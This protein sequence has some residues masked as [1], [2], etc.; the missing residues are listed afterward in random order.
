MPSDVEVFAMREEERRVKQEAKE[1][2]KN[3]SI[4]DKNVVKRKNFKALLSEDADD[5]QFYEQLRKRDSDKIL[6]NRQ[7]RADR[8]FVK[9][10]LHDFIA[11]KR[12]M[13]LVQYALGVKKEEM[14]KL[15]EIAQAEEQKLLDDE[16]ALEEDAG[17][18][19]ME[20]KAKLEKIQ[21]IKK[22]NV[23]IMSIRSDMSKNED[24][25]KD[26][27]RYR[28]FLDKLTPRE[29]FDEHTVKKK[30]AKTKPLSRKSIFPGGPGAATAA[31]LAAGDED[32]SGANS[33]E[34]EGEAWNEDDEPL[35]Y[36]HTPQQLLDI[37]AEL[38]EN[39]LAL[40][41]NCQETEET[42]EELKQKI[43]DT[44]ARMWVGSF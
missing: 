18:A 8:H 5:L 37:F 14:R 21:E 25:L 16:K 31:A 17:K 24:Q 43:V 28:Q 12:E 32:D 29:F 35:L 41:Q 23:Q 44:E 13:F 11:K 7:T 4:Y 3:Q 15:E 22:L 42:L 38:E 20:T 9:E 19:E 2:M 10:N 33:D 6:I 26:L 27:Q 30:T 1:K 40:I 34:D 39:N 36:F